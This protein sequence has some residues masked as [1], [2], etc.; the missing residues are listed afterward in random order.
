MEK[1]SKWRD[2]P[3]G[4]HPLIPTSAKPTTLVSTLI[5]K[6]LLG[7]ILVLVRLPVIILLVLLLV[8]IDFIT[9]AIPIG[10]ISRFINRGFTIV[11]CRLIF[12]F[13]GFF[14]IDEYTE[15]LG[16]R[17]KDP[18]GDI[19]SYA[20]NDVVIVNHSSYVD[21]LYLQYRYSP[22]FAV[23]PNDR[24]PTNIDGKL[25]PMNLIQ[26]LQNAIY[27]RVQLS[28]RSVPT[29]DLLKKI[30][31]SW[32]GPLVILP[33]GTTSNG[34]G[35]LNIAP[36]FTSSS[37]IKSIDSVHVVGI[38]YFTWCYPVSYPSVGSFILHFL[39]L[40]SQF[41]NL[42]E[43]K[44]LC[45]NKMTPLPTTSNLSLYDDD[46]H[47]WFDTTFKTL[48]SLVNTRRTKITSHDKLNF[49]SYWNG[50]KVDSTSS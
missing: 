48:A 36:V 40:I 31:S 2:G 47:T 18:V 3:T 13:M 30:D 28:T 22:I 27:S 35:L 26:A 9:K 24:N 41:S 37:N 42:I 8:A 20:L 16:N 1:Y 49:M 45:R 17:S 38:N 5:F 34:Q 25:V 33:E 15:S 21:I 50:Y 19:R 7:P 4:I 12:L 29:Q 23:P 11:L 14:K 32:M 46:I 43:I 39:R 44:Y 6:V 10:F